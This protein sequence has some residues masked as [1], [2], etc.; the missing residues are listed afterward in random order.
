MLNSILSFI[1][2]NSFILGL[3]VAF[4]LWLQSRLWKLIKKLEHLQNRQSEMDVRF[5]DMDQKRVT[6]LEKKF[7]S[8]YEKQNELAQNLTAL[9]KSIEHIVAGVTRIEDILMKR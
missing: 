2:D 6:T 9:S 4:V 3:F 1:S 5:M 7:D 8:L